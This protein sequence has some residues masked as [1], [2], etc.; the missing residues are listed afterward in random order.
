MQLQV[1]IVTLTIHLRSF[2]PLPT[3]INLMSIAIYAIPVHYVNL[4]HGRSYRQ[5]PECLYN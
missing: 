3:A 1:A 5:N 4:A 2:D